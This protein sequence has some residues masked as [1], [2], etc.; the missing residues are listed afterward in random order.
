MTVFNIETLNA[1]GARLY[2][3]ADSITNVA[4][5]EM[6]LDI[7]LAARVCSNFATLRFRVAE[8]A[9]MALTQ[10]GAATRRDLLDALADAES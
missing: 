2:D 10:D 8:I 4:A 3:H 6:E 1:L 7:R 5:H 9:E